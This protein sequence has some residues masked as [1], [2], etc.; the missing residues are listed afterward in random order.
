MNIRSWVKLISDVSTMLPNTLYISVQEAIGL[1][2]G[3][4]ES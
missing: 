3:L 1:E 4:D 2:N